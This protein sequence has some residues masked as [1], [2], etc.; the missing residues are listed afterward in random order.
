[1]LE[2]LDKAYSLHLSYRR[3][4]LSK[5]TLREVSTLT[6]GAKVVSPQNFIV[7]V[8]AGRTVFRGRSLL[9]ALRIRNAFVSHGVPA[10]V[11]YSLPLEGGYN[12]A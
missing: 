8:T 11:G 4:A 12:A 9:L 6:T 5:N 2:A 10:E 3:R 1:V 7:V